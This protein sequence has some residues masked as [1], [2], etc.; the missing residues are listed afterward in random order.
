MFIDWSQNSDFKTTICVYSI[1][2]KR[3]EPFISMPI[4]WKELSRAADLG[5]EKFFF[6]AGCGPEK[7]QAS[8][9]FRSRS[10]RNGPRLC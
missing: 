4:S 7:N 2:A 5:D 9:R 8:R 10:T 3:E 1:R 6:Y